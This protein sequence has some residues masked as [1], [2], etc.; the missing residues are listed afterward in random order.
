MELDGTSLSGKV[1]AVAPT[2][3][4]SGNKI[5]VQW[6]PM[7]NK[8]TA[9]IWLT[10]T[11][12]FKTGGKDSYKLVKEVAVKKEEAIIDVSDSPSS[13]YKVVIETPYNFLNRWI[14]ANQ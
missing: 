8:G 7:D 4:L 5:R 1:S 10:T 11:N 9:R 12:N 13:F 14:V 6:K 2:A 3:V